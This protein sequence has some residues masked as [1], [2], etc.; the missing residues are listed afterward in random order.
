MVIK[1]EIREVIRYYVI[2]VFVNIIYNF[3]KGIKLEFDLVFIYNC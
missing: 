2:Y 3:V 1:T